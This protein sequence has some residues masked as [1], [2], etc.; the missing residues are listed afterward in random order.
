MTLKTDLSPEDLVA[1]GERIKA[2]RKHLNLSQKELAASL[3][4]ANSYLSEIEHG[5]AYPAFEFFHK[6]S[7]MYNM[8]LNYLFHGTG[9]MFLPREKKPEKQVEWLD[10]I[11]TSDD[12]LWFMEH[13]SMFRNSIMGMA[14]KFLIENEQ[15]LKK[16]VQKYFSRNKSELEEK[17]DEA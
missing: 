13:S 2:L 17:N 7:R 5:N 9:E 15:F 3:G 16:N 4:M 11:R 6:I 12:L 10:D 8:D 1:L 14:E